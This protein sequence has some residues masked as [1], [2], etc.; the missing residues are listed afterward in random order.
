MR[1]YTRTN[2]GVLKYIDAEETNIKSTNNIIELLEQ[3]DLVKI[4]FC[5]VVQNENITRLFEVDYVAPDKYYMSLVNAHMGFTICDGNFVEKEYNPEIKSI[6]TREKLDSVEYKL[7]NKYK[8]IK[9]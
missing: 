6:I 5:P 2:D 9:H 8:K 7:E 1:N 4:E 3:G